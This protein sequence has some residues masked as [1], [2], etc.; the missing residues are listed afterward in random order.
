MRIMLIEMYHN[1]KVRDYVRKELFDRPVDETEVIFR[2]LMEKG[3]IRPCDPRAL[4]AM[5]ISYLVSWYLQSFIL[6]YNAP[7]GRDRIEKMAQA[8]IGLIVDLLKLEGGQA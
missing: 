3:K 6:S 1:E 8:Q 5:F 4:A 2:K 7:H